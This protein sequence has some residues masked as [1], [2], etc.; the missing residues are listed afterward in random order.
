MCTESLDTTSPADLERGGS[1]DGN[2]AGN[3]AS[4]RRSNSQ[5]ST[6]DEVDIFIDQNIQINSN[7]QMR[8]EYLWQWTLK[9][10]DMNQERR[11]CELR[12]DMFRSNVLCVY[13]IWLFIVACQA[14]VVPQ[15]KLMIVGLSIATFA[16]TVGCF[17]VM[18]EEFPR[19]FPAGIRRHSQQLVNQRANRTF[20]ICVFIVVMSVA[21]SSTI[22]SCD[23]DQY[24][25]CEVAKTND[26]ANRSFQAGEDGDAIDNGTALAG[27][28]VVEALFILPWPGVNKTFISVR[29]LKAQVRQYVYPEFIVFTWVLC[30]ISLSTGLRLYYLVKTFLAFIMVFLYSAIILATSPRT[31]HRLDSERFAK[32]FYAGMPLSSQMVILLVVFLTM[33][34]YHARLVEVTSRL[35]FIW[36]EQAEKELANMKSNRYLND[37]LIKNILPDHVASYYLTDGRTDEQLYAKMHEN[38]GVMFA[39]I[40]NFRDFYSED[41]E[42]GKA[43]IR[44]LNEIICDFD[45]L[46]EDPDFLTVEKIKTM[47]ASYMAASGLNPK[48]QTRRGFNDED[49]ICNLVDFALAMRQ[50]LLDVNK[51]AFNTFYLRVGISHGPLVSGVIGAHKPVYDIWGNTVNVASRMDSTGESW[52]IQVPDYTATLLMSR[53]YSCVVIVRERLH[54]IMHTEKYLQHFSRVVKSKSRARGV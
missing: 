2:R 49:C 11:Y 51:D 13:V 50:K 21:S 8:N 3:K 47:G 52:R 48:M 6:T 31:F 41:I 5:S 22:L 45:S 20:F 42:N 18:A 15:C 29:E 43:C 17:M 33:V 46:L 34:T 37:L 53:G 28:G 1:A 25:L 10:K 54:Q 44:I 23:L 36:K 30:L 27:D 40:P 39:S 12:E 7:K 26:I 19:C 16:L 35:D 32:D 4:K 38:C 9:F 14:F 24:L